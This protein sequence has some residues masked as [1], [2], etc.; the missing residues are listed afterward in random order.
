MPTRQE[1]GDEKG[2]EEARR[3]S[4]K[5]TMHNVRFLFFQPGPQ[6]TKK[7]KKWCKGQKKKTKGKKE[8]REWRIRT[9]RPMKAERSPERKGKGCE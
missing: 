4:P 9:D 8:R 6:Q 2:E 1:G 7:K 3:R 5:S